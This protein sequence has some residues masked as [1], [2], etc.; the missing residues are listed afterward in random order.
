MN[1]GGFFKAFQ[2]MSI[3]STWS[4][5]A[6]EDGKVTLKEATELATSICEILGIPLEIDV[7]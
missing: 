5:E 6:L 3:I 7:D 2:V 4:V 1:I